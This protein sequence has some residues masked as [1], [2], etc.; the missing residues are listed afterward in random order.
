MTSL[1]RRDLAVVSM[2]EIMQQDWSNYIH[3]IFESIKIN[4]GLKPAPS[5][6]DSGGRFI[7]NDIIHLEFGTWDR[8]VQFGWRYHQVHTLPFLCHFWRDGG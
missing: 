5:C 3:N 8:A 2:H 1:D 6:P 7:N 4:S